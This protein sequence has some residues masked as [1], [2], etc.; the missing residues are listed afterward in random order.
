MITKQVL[1][2]ITLIVADAMVY[3]YPLYRRKPENAEKPRHYCA[4]A[5]ASQ[6]EA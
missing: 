4:I 5:H 1:M 6:A 3:I 2:L